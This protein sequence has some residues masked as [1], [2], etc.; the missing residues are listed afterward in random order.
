M[1]SSNSHIQNVYSGELNRSIVT[2]VK[3]IER[4]PLGCD[5]GYF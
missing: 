3:T 1:T 5:I 4:L 2:T